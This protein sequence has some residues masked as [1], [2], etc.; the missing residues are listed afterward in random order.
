MFTRKS[1]LALCLATGSALALEA[2]T[3]A[4]Q[5]APAA[6]TPQ[7]TTATATSASTVDGGEPHWIRP[8]TPEQR[9]LRLGVAEDPGPDPDTNK[10]WWRYGH[11]YFIEKADR[12]WANWDNP[13]QEGWVRP[14]GF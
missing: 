1:F 9:K 12:R 4:A 13:P 8:E 14:F 3:P 11:L 7:Q 10:R 5:P 2:Q 6:Q